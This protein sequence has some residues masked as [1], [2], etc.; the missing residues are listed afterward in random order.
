LHHGRDQATLYLILA[1]TD[2]YRLAFSQPVALALRPRACKVKQFGAHRRELPGRG[3]LGWAVYADLLESRADVD[4]C[5]VVFCF[6]AG[7]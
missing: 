5:G 2:L 4:G 6:V 1:T 3:W 7:E